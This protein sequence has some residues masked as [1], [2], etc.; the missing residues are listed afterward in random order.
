GLLLLASVDAG[1]LA[2]VEHS[3]AAAIAR[4]ARDAL[5]ALVIALAVA[6]ALQEPRAVRSMIPPW[7]VR[8]NIRL[9]L[10]GALVGRIAFPRWLAFFSAAPPPCASGHCARSL[11][12]I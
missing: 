5:G 6:L 2:L 1:T 4:F 3:A 11:S 10:P 7:G 8:P 9:K 12:A